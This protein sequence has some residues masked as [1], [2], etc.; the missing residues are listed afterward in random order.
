MSIATG[1]SLIRPEPGLLGQTVVVMA[2]APASDSKPP[3]ER[4]LK[5]PG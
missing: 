4:A 2:A 5:A 3:G 1:N